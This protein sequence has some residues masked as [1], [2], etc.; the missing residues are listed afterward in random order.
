MKTKVFKILKWVLVGALALFVLIALFMKM[1][2]VPMEARTECDEYARANV[3]EL[4]RMTVEDAYQF[5]YDSCFR[6]RGL[7]PEGN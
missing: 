5:L 6:Q 2:V 1:V 4:K 3:S 7:N